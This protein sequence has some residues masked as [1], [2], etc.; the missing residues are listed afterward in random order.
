MRSAPVWGSMLVT[1]KG[2]PMAEK[3]LLFLHGIANDDE[4]RSWQQA[5]DAALRR[6][7]SKTLTERSF[8]VLAPSYLAML[9]GDA[10]S[11]DI[12]PTYTYKR[13]SEQAE[14]EAAGRYLLRRSELERAIMAVPRPSP[15]PLSAVPHG[16]VNLFVRRFFEQAHRYISSAARRH[17]IYKHI[18]DQIP[19]DGD[20]VIIAHSLG[21]VVAADLLYHLPPH[22]RVKLLVTIGSPLSHEM[23]RRHLNRLKDTFPFSSVEAW[24][25]VIG[26]HDYVTMSRGVA[27]T[28]PEALDVFVDNGIGESVH[29]AKR[30][31]DQ[32]AIVRALNWVTQDPGSD[33][34]RADQPLT[35]PLLA[36]VAGAQFALRVEQ[37]QE[38]GARRGRYGAGRALVAEEVAAALRD[39]GL[40][41]PVLQRLLRDNSEVLRG[42]LTP[43][44]ILPLLLT[45]FEGNPIWPYQIKTDDK[46]RRTALANLAGDLGVPASWA[47]TAEGAVRD[48]REAHR[49]FDWWKAAVAA[50]GIAAVVAAPALVLAAAPTALAGGAAIVSGLAALGP[51]GMLGGLAVVGVVG[52]VGG[53]VATQALTSGDIQTVQQNVIFVQALALARKRLQLSLPGYPEWF[54]LVAMESQISAEHGRLRRVSDSDA[55]SVK[56]AERKLLAITTALRWMR[57]QKLGPKEISAK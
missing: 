17:A 14:M 37:A 19:P 11:N 28:F 48:A 27:G 23:L 47:E 12:R 5:L 36:V 42:R 53:T 39:A 3:T 25:N 49:N 54:T 44:D 35:G 4:E 40:E 10:P 56:D 16:V 51:G 13:T 50:A 6:D 2:D 46:V 21:S 7:G 1:T 8:K 32:E 18:I 30:Y 24:M 9:D 45:A 38:P 22:V 34:G 52:G 31:L 43:P 15:G 33:V 55:P 57:E 29:S 20:L 41:H 26:H